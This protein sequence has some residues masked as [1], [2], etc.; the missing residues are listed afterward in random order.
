MGAD[1]LTDHHER[2]T[3]ITT[4]LTR[5]FTFEASHQLAWHPG[6]CANLHGHSY[7]LEVT[8]IGPLNADGVV[9]DFGDIKA[10]VTKHVLTEYDHAHLNDFLPNPTAELVA[11]DIADR[12]LNA[13]LAV[14]AVTVHETAACAA[15]VH[16][17]NT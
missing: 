7:R 6:R 3:M 8:V 12:L 4:S 14:S 2:G 11:A 15:T 9:I 1:D 16:V 13:G 5:S 17:R 10:R